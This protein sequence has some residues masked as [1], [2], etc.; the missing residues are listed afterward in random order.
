MM[1]RLEYLGHTVN[2]KTTRKSY[3]QKKQ[4]KND[5]SEWQI[6]E[7][8]HE[9]IIDE[10]V[11][12][13]VQKIREG[14]RKPARLGEMCVL[15]GIMYCGD[16]GN[17]MYNVRCQ[18]WD[19]SKEYFTCATYR[20]QRGGCSSHQVRTEVVEKLLL[21]SLKELIRYASEYESEFV[22]MVLQKTQ[23][24]RNAELREKKRD[25]DQSKARI[26]ELDQIMQ[27][28]YEDNISGKISDERFIKLTETYENEQR[29]LQIKLT[30]LEKYLADAQGKTVNLK[31]FLQYVQKYTNLE[32]LDAEVIRTFVEKVIVYEREPGKKRRGVRLKIIYNC[33]GEIKIAKP[34]EKTT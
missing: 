28:L 33:I 24:A 18:G 27:R 22:E 5:P 1:S 3:K 10:E 2:F 23:K 21:Q 13:I 7:N 16:C 26:A 19:H 8:T 20:K 14:K 4:L 6:F 30:T 32:Q 25:Y 9:A 17:K 15:S 29:Q 11:F 12:K 31:T 34:P